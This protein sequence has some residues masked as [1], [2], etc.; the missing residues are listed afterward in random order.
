MTP[1]SRTAWRLTLAVLL[2]AVIPLIAAIT[3]AKNMVSSVAAQLHN[4]RVG[5]EL[6]RSL[7]LYQELARA[8]QAGMRYEADAIAAAE[9]LRKAAA[10]GA[11]PAIRD[12]LERVF[13]RYAN[14]AHI[15]V[16]D[17]DGNVVVEKKR[18]KPVDEASELQLEVRRP[19]TDR[20]DGPMLLTVFVTPKARFDE[21]DQV[22]E[23][24]RVY[25]QIEGSR[26]EVEQI[27]LYYF[28]ALLIITVLAAGAIGTLMARSVTRRIAALSRATQAVGAGDLSVR[29]PAKG[30]DELAGLALAFNNMLDEVER[31]R[32]RIEFLQR[33]GTWQEM[34]RRLA[35]EI[36]NPLTPIQLA[37]EEV[38]A[39]YKGDDDAFRALLETTRGVVTEEVG[40]LRRLV[41]EFSAFARLP[42]AE[43][44]EYDASTFMREQREHMALFSD[45]DSG[46][47]T[48]DADLL[49]RAVDVS[50]EIPD[51]NM[52]VHIDRQMMHRVLVNLVRNAAQAVSV[53][54][55]GRGR[56]RVGL[57]SA[58][59]DW[60]VL[61]IEDDGSG[62]PTDMRES[63]FD[64]YVTTKKDG[65]GLGLSIVKKIVMEHGGTV[66]AGESRWG[67][68][69]MTIRLPRSGSAASL[70][71]RD[72]SNTPR[73]SRNPPLQE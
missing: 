22:A 34:A 36:K 54:A 56:V 17:E 21:Q 9:P 1:P 11:Q 62:I 4:P 27:H 72:T 14:L 13:P 42:R 59:H 25:R 31:S 65:T 57:S 20:D 10:S 60:V 37:V 24:V 61:E 41:T 32:A 39:R 44:Q 51:A 47:R 30:S 50:W 35:H 15:A 23:T 55:S 69:K 28:A 40:T 26:G 67:G 29:V 45:D 64:P 43:L 6:E 46:L 8:T 16:T 38:H 19:L 63:I 5:M 73:S 18:P 49:E 3:I 70:A 48:T 52:P 58:G 71:A 68:A 2:A 33:M 53:T 7:E 12:E 66:E